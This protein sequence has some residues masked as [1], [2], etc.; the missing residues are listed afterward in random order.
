MN[1]IRR[2]SDCIF[3]QIVAGKM[4]C[5]KVFEDQNNL[6]FLDIFPN[7]EGLSVLIPKQHHV[8]D[9]AQAPLDAV[10]DLLRAA[11]I[12]AEK[13][14][15]AYENVGRCAIVIEGMMIDHLHIKVIPL[16]QTAN[17]KPNVQDDETVAE[18]SL[19]FEAYPGYITTKTMDQMADK[20]HLAAIADKINKVANTD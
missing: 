14:T 1:Q 6:G 8:S 18:E 19:Y 7:T 10:I 17:R 2:V 15:K 20:N 12:L 13:I 11:R 4:P 16:H 9:F 5:F 3:C